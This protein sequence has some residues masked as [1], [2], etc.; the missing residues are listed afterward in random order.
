MKKIKLTQGKYAL[1][2]DVDYEYLNQWKWHAAKKSPVKVYMHRLINKTKNGQYTD[3]INRDTLDNRKNNLRTVT[4]QQ[5]A[6][7]CNLSKNNKSGYNGVH[8]HKNR[9]VAKI[10]VNYKNIGLGRFTNKEDAINARREGERI[11]A[12][13]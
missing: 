5:N 9:W 6:F 4:N 1:V 10:K 8:W 2:D 13:I 12:K 11:Y 3:H 7:N